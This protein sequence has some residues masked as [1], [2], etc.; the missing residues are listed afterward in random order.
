MG[1]HERR[2]PVEDV[3]ICLLKEGAERVCVTCGRSVAPSSKPKEWRLRHGAKAIC[4]CC[5]LIV[6]A[7]GR[8]ST[9]VLPIERTE[10][11]LLIGLNDKGREHGERMAPEDRDRVADELVTK[12]RNRAADEWIEQL[13]KV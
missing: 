11:G 10:D 7:S 5:A 13:K 6:V 9:D 2:E 12:L 3:V 4:A 8:D 1:S